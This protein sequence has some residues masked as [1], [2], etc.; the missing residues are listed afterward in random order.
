MNK[1][2][3][4]AGWWQIK[5]DEE[6]NGEQLGWANTPPKDCRE[7]NI[8]SCWNEVFPE[9]FSYDGTAWYFKE[10]LFQPQELDERAVLCFEG[11]NYRCE[12]YINGQPVGMHEG[13][14]TSFSIPI[15]HALR[16]GSVNL[17]AIRVNSKLDDTTLPPSGVDWFN[18]GGIYRPVYIQTTRAAFIDDYTIKTRIDGTVNLSARIINSGSAGSYRVVAKITDQNGQDVAQEETLYQLG[19][20]ENREG[21]IKLAVQAPHLWKL[22]AAYLY[23]LHLELFD[24]NGTTYDTIEKRFGI[25]EFGSVGHK[26]LL[27]GEEIK[28]VGCAKHDEYPLTGRSV[29]RE[30][31]VKDY[32][33]LRQ[34][35]ANFVRLSHY[36]HNQ[37]EHELL[38]E[39]G[40]V[41][42][43]EIPLVYLH[44]FQMTS[45]A[46]LSKGLHMLAEMIHTEKNTTSIMFWSLFVECETYL[47][48]TRGFVKAMV[49]STRALDDTRLV[50]MASIHPLTDVTYDLFDVI[51]VNYWEGWYGG[52]SIEDAMRFLTTMAKRYPDKPLLITSHGWEGMYGERSYVEKT[53]WSED[54]QSDYLPRI[55]DTYKGFKNIVGEIV[56]TFADF[57]VSNWK[58]TSQ[59]KENFSYLR[60]PMLVNQKGM[61]DFYRRPKS[62]YYMMRDKFAQWQE[63]VARPTNTYGQNLQA[64]IFSN[65]RLAG[66]VAAFDFIDRI[67]E[68]LRE[69]KSLNVVFAS[70]GSQV[71]FLETLVCNQMF[72]DWGRINAFHLDEFVGAGSDTSYG[73]SHWLMDRFISQLPFHHFEVLN[74]QAEDLNDECNRYATCLQRSLIDLACIGIGENGHLAFNDPPVADF[75]DPLLVKVID[76]DETCREQQFRDGV[77]P[78]L[79]SVPE[80]ALTLTIPA[81][82]QAKEILCIVPGTHKAISV[83]KTINA[84]VATKC[85]ATILRRHPNVRLY[86]DAESA[87][88]IYPKS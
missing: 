88:F 15:T 19:A 67:Q 71:E 75:V 4:L 34:M 30:Q 54:S 61:V 33:L 87:K 32:D 79:A 60:R 50:V 45:P 72:V 29:T 9:Y 35:N 51:G 28:L 22:R 3:S 86:L 38:D 44:E 27:N 41:A 46:M 81:I 40:M 37:L 83:W 74:G 7:I 69:K 85:P 1:K 11:V 63:L 77:F 23:K 52:E 62:T 2:I 82:M 43:S 39:L 6:D 70:A 17:L 8:P 76:L 14:F 65:R 20:G 59:A 58:D 42:I 21:N 31:L 68:L 12:I 80:K 78:D 55:A 57:R 5:F 24:A 73:F 10:V 56:W 64:K 49:D 84:E 66:E 48:T 13:G 53:P 25:R 26:I 16:S 47:P 18:Y 36:P